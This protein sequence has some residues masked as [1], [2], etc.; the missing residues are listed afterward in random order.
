MNDEYVERVTVFCL[1]GGNE[2]PI[3]GICQSRKQRLRQREDSELRIE[4]QLD[5][6]PRGVST[7]AY[8]WS[9]SAQVG[10]LE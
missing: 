2:T 4:L 7:T 8:T 10:N 9:L 5:Q 3:V 1:G 6:V